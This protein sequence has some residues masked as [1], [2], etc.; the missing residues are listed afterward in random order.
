MHCFQEAALLL[1]VDEYYS[2]GWKWYTNKY[3]YRHAQVAWTAIAFFI[4]CVAAF[5]SGHLYMMH[6]VVHKIPFVSYINDPVED[7]LRISP[8]SMLGD[9]SVNVSVARYLVEWYIHAREGYSEALSDESRWKETLEALLRM[10]SRKEF[11]DF[12]STM[13]IKTNPRSP[14]LNYYLTRRD[15]SDIEVIFPEHLPLP[16]VADATFRCV[17][18][19]NAGEI[20]TFWKATVK[21]VMP[22]MIEVQRKEEKNFEFK[23]IGYKL[24]LLGG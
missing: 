14:V 11:R 17:E 4:L 22:S 3:W 18:R 2:E 5:I 15:I 1:K 23:V 10:S 20:V 12:I 9:E 16:T 6:Q 24:S 13:N 7:V 21:F 8:I 19:G